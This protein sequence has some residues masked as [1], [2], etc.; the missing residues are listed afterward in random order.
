MP[1]CGSGKRSY[2]FIMGMVQALTCFTLWLVRFHTIV[3]V[4]VVA[5]TTMLG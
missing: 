2:I 3:S 4:V 1:I 5:M